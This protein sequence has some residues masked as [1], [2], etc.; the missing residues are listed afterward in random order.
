MNLSLTLHA[1]PGASQR[2]RNR[3]REHGPSFEVRRRG[4]CARLGGV[5]AVLLVASDGW[6]GWLP[7]DELTLPPTLE[8]P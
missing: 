8:V 3:V 4:H 6:L 2:T 1:R 7:L 5:D